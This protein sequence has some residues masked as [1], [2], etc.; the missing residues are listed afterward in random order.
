[1][2]LEAAV[3]GVLWIPSSVVTQTSPLSPADVVPGVTLEVHPGVCCGLR[4]LRD[5]GRRFGLGRFGRARTG[6]CPRG[7]RDHGNRGEP[8]VSGGSKNRSGC[9][10]SKTE[11]LLIAAHL[12]LPCKVGQSQVS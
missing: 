10:V 4:S 12:G 11:P 5:A 9:S 1:M 6:R 2:T 3:G 7:K 8:R